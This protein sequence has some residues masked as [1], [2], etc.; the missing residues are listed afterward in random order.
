[1]KTGH[2]FVGSSKRSTDF[3]SDIWKWGSGPPLF[4]YGAFLIV[5]ND[6]IWFSL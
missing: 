5:I 1:M 4:Y 3:F 6:K 2:Q